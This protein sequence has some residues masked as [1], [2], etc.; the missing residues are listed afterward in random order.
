MRSFSM[1]AHLFVAAFFLWPIIS[2]GADDSLLV[3]GPYNY[4]DLSIFLLEAPDVSSHF[5]ITLEQALV[6]HRAVI[7][8]DNS[9]TL[10]IENL[11]DS[12]IYLQSGDLIKGGQQDRMIESDMILAAHETSHDLHVFCI[13]KGRSFQRGQEP[14]ATFSASTEMAPVSHMRIVANHEL[15]SQLLSPHVGG[16]MAPDTSELQLLQSIDAMPQFN[17]VGDLVQESIWN[18]VM[19]MQDSLDSVLQDSVT[20]N[21]S[22]TSLELTL[23]HAS[24]VKVQSEFEDH[25]LDVVRNSPHSIGV[26]YALG[27]KIVGADRYSSHLLFAAMWPKL[28]KAMATESLVEGNAYSSHTADDVQN[29]LHASSFGKEGKKEVNNRTEITA[30]ESS[31]FYHL[32]TRDM[33]YRTLIHMSSL[34]K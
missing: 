25:L 17:L 33:K 7:H 5:Y 27:G 1:K 19:L 28:L 32:V 4:K 6:H 21:A 24:V 20:R 2:L 14:I 8:E 16:S 34:K 26:V 30:S 18:D 13:E 15:T 29:F 3:R 31:E 10:W 23:E 9:Q 11:S 22:P 12:D